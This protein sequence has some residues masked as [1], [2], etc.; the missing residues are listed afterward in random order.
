LSLKNP[1]EIDWQGREWHGTREIVEKAKKEGYDGIIIHNVKD[2][3]NNTTKT[4]PHNVYAAFSPE[5]IK[6]ATDNRGTFDGAN[7]DI[8]FSL[9]EKGRNILNSKGMN[10][11]FNLPSL[12]EARKNVPEDTRNWLT[13]VWNKIVSRKGEGINNNSPKDL[14][15]VSQKTKQAVKE[16]YG[17]NVSKQIIT[18]NGLGHI[19]R[20]HGKDIARELNDKQIPMTAETI[21]NIPD[22]LA[23]PDNVRQGGKTGRDG[24]DTVVLSKKYADGTIHVVDAI[25]KNNVLEVWTSYTWNNAKTEKKNSARGVTTTVSDDMGSE[26]RGTIPTSQKRVSSEPSSTNKYTKNSGNKQDESENIH[27]YTQ[28]EP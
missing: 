25:L 15:N 19:Y 11:K 17:K 3:Y 8:R 7:P 26:Q 10:E 1:L 2:N 4:K 22:V 24:Y 23:N 21:A 18:P 13:K 20:E 12:E 5:Q 6:S 16:F 28:K 27:K 9:S 14:G